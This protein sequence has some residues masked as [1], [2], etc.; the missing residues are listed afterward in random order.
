[1]TF[2]SSIQLH[3]ADILFSPQQECSDPFI[4]NFARSSMPPYLP[5]ES[6]Y[7]FR[8]TAQSQPL[9]GQPIRNTY[10]NRVR[11]NGTCVPGG[12]T[13]GPFA[14]CWP[15]PNVYLLAAGACSRE[16]WR[17]LI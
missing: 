16:R 6:C 13:F 2:S 5:L 11:P 4:L 8:T 7:E 1:M 17:S 3:T 12:T 14:D 10:A 9:C 15:S